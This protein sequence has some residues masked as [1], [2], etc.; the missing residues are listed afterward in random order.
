MEEYVK[1]II[2]AIIILVLDGIWIYSN[3][4]MYSDAVKAIQKSEMRIKPYAAI[5]AYSFVLFASLFI[6]IP[7]TKQNVKKGDSIEQKLYKSFIYGGAAGFA[8]YGVYN[9][10]SLSIYK[11]YTLN[12]A[13]IDT[14]WGTVLNTTIVFIYLLLD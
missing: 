6:A 8:V 1:Y 5:V 11:D 7:F 2:I 4:Q 12:L 13:L 14:T 9:F 3:L 10:T